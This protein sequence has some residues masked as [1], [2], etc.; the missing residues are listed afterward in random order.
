MRE[1][2]VFTYLDLKYNPDFPVDRSVLP[3]FPTKPTD[4]LV[5]FVKTMDILWYFPSEENLPKYI[6]MT[7]DSLKPVF[8]KWYN[9]R[10]GAE[11]GTVSNI[12][13]I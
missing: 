4:T 5:G 7:W 12:F 6:S 13:A 3:G 8:I 9:L 1:E 2:I 11:H 10:F